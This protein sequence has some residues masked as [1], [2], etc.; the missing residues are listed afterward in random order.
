MNARVEADSEASGDGLNARVRT[1][2]L[3]ARVIRCNGT[4][5]FAMFDS[6][7]YSP[8]F[9]TGHRG[10]DGFRAPSRSMV[11]RWRSRIRR[12]G[13]HFE[14]RIPQGWPRALHFWAA[15]FKSAPQKVPVRQ[16]A[17]KPRFDRPRRAP[18]NAQRSAR[19]LGPS[20]HSRLRNCAAVQ[21]SRLR[22]LGRVA[23]PADCKCRRLLLCRCALR[24]RLRGRS[25]RRFAKSIN[26]RERGRFDLSH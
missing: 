14:R 10:L 17:T 11:H 8:R 25:A 23:V 16:C 18:L 24:R 4:V 5:R 3:K 22:E 1:L 2:R 9:A 20:T 21:P 7:A 6:V 15:T 12:R 13:H 19:V 26:R